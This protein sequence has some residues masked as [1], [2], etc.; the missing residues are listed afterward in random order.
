[1][2]YRLPMS[3]VFSRL[4]GPQFPRVDGCALF[5][6]HCLPY[7]TLNSIHCLYRALG[8]RTSLL[9]SSPSL[10][11]LSR[12]LSSNAAKQVEIVCIVRILSMI[13][14]IILNSARNRESKDSGIRESGERTLPA[15]AAGR[16]IYLLPSVSFLT[17]PAVSVSRSVRPDISAHLSRVNPVHGPRRTLPDDYR[18]RRRV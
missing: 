17:S 8:F 6:V 5:S 14:A 15:S 16:E 7:R 12:F 13:L 4:R 11:S 1:M 18:S 9:S 2:C 10:L 3:V